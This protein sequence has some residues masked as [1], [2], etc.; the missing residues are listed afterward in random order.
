V[1]QRINLPNPTDE[2]RL[3]RV[4]DQPCKV[5]G[6]ELPQLTVARLF[7]Q[8]I[9]GVWGAFIPITALSCEFPDPMIAAHHGQAAG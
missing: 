8:Q 2:H 5:P 3:V 6:N 7:G 9:G 1:N 4:H